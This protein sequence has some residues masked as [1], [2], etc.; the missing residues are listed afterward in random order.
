MKLPSK[1]LEQLAFNIRSRIQEHM[2]IVMD[3]STN[4]LTKNTYLSHYNP[5]R[6]NFR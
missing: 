1:I 6:N 3:E 2:L 5:I 4:R